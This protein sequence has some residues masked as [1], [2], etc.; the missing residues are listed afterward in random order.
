MLQK[1][2]I[3]LL[4]L[5]TYSW[6]WLRPSFEK[7]IRSNKMYDV[8]DLTYLRR[9]NT[10]LGRVDPLWFPR[11]FEPSTKGIRAWEYGLL[12]DKTTFR[13]KTVLDAGVGNSRLPLYL[14]KRGAKI[15]MLDMEEPL[16]QTSVKRDKNLRF[17]LGDMTALKFGDSSFDRVICIS[18]IE[19]V[20][21]K[22]AGQFYSEKEYIERAIKSIRELA[23]VTK[24]GG[25]FYLTTD[26][27][28]P[29]QK[30]DKWPGSK[31]KIRGGF[32]WYCLEIFINEMKKGRIKLDND[33]IVDKDFLLESKNRANY[34]GRYFT[35]F[36]F[37]G[38]KT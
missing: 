22:P 31:E 32:P 13:K 5:G 23:R 17:V 6:W 19:H 8:S 34:R 29:Q 7:E 10:N 3:G 25:V 35:T 11:L 12:L 38:T 16:E 18:A 15:T 4:E 37:R 28:L 30:T 1:R 21:M 9:I 26:F 24:K 2:E 14:S 20:D 27:Y 36:S 33:P